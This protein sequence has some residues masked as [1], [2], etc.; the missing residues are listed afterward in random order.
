MSGHPINVLCSFN[1]V[2]IV[3]SVTNQR[4]SNSHFLSKIFC[5]TA[6]IHRTVW[7]YFPAD[8]TSGMN[9]M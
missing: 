6:Y 3:T 7:K 1:K 9:S 8:F 4:T 5:H 2:M